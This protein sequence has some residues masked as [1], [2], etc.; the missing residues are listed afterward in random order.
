MRKKIRTIIP[1]LISCVIA[2]GVITVAWVM[3]DATMKGITIRSNTGGVSMLIKKPTDTEYT[4]EYVFTEDLT[5]I[6]CVKV[7]ASLR[8]EDDVD[9]TSNSDYVKEIQMVVK[10]SAKVGLYATVSVDG[11]LPIKVDCNNVDITTNTYIQ[12]VNPK[13]T[14]LTFHIWVDGESYTKPDVGNITITLH[15]EAV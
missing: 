8:S 4:D 14:T 13:D 10:P 9:V 12:N 15:G 2:F 11:D 3:Q 6:P 1:I 5:L 7:D